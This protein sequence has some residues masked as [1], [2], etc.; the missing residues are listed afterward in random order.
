MCTN[1][2][3]SSS[4]RKWELSFDISH[5]Y[6]GSNYFS[7]VNERSRFEACILASHSHGDSMH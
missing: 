4:L 3:S 6:L 5:F 1:P 2:G 7:E